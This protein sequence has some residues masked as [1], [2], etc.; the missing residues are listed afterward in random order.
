MLI[1]KENEEHKLS[2]LQKPNICD[3]GLGFLVD[4]YVLIVTPKRNF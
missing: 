2:V 1:R 4:R 3:M